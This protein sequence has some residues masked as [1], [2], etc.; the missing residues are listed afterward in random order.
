MF[1]E[2]WGSILGETSELTTKKK[3]LMDRLGLSQ[4]DIDRTFRSMVQKAAGKG[5]TP[6]PEQMAILEDL[7][8]CCHGLSL[9]RGPPGTDKT[10]TAAMVAE[11]YLQVHP[12][13]GVLVCAPSNGAVNRVSSC[14]RAWMAVSDDKNHR[15]EPLQAHR[16][17]HEQDYARQQ[18]CPGQNESRITDSE[19]DPSA[20]EA[21]KED[22][23]IDD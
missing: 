18:L 3:F 4:V 14:F 20:S 13:I 1:M 15:L 5:F 21:D 12:D 17:Y 23:E 16:K 8:H 7:G 10:T 11:A 2:W 19:V 22:A 9:W 6:N